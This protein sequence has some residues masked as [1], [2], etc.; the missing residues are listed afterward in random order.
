[1]PDTVDI[2]WTYSVSKDGDS[3]KDSQRFS[4]TPTGDFKG[5]NL[6]QSIPTAGTTLNFGSVV[7]VASFAVK[8][9][10]AA[11]YVELS[12]NSDFSKPFTKITA[13]KSLPPILATG[14]A[15]YAKANTAPVLISTDFDGVT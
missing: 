15:V 14:Q 1:M 3:P 2:G 8:N 13:L 12:M 7:S 6:V 4:Y 9:N 5:F 10:D 11:N